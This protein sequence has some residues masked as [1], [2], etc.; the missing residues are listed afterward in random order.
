MNFN[1]RRL[2]SVLLAGLLLLP[3]CST[4][5]SPEKL[6]DPGKPITVTVWHYYNGNIKEQFDGLVAEFNESVGMEKGIVVDAQ[7]QGDVSQLADAVFNS[8]SKTIGAAPMPDVFAAYPENA[9]RVNQVTPLADLK[10]YFTQEELETFRQE[11]LSEGRFGSENQLYIL[12]IAKSTE[13]L[14]VNREY[15]EAFAAENG[16]TVADLR[17]WEG[18]AAVAKVYREKTG[19]GFFG[20]DANANFMLQSGV[21]LGSELFTFGEDGT[22]AFSMSE[23]VARKIWENYYIPYITGSFVKTGR[24]SSDDAKTGTVMAYTGSTAGAAYFPTEVTFSESEVFPISPLTLPYP[25]Y[26]E[27]KPF[28][29]QQGAGMCISRTDEAHQYAAAL[30]LKWFTE[31]AQ[32]MRFAVSTGY[33]PV[34]NEALTA[35]RLKGALAEADV[36]NPAIKASFATTTEM[37]QTYTFYNNKP[38]QGSY[39]VRALLETDLF[40]KILRDLEALAEQKAAG[41]D[42]QAVIAALTSEAAFVE[43]YESLQE[44]AAA[45]MTQ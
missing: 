43:W 35:E 27:G 12:P 34:K 19:K 9:F 10:A 17:T 13:N 33:L 28:A 29:V 23:T 11:F 36:T 22:V 3:G 42:P 41:A 26:A 39:E 6:L 18:L 21:Q 38:F 4:Q 7:S 1:H 37:L 5:Q 8:A 15:W 40:N 20:I 14:Y 31:P 16:F 45:T 2:L 44:K 25:Y 24:F 30:F 32:N